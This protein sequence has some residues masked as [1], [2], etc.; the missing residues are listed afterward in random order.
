MI[1]LLINKEKAREIIVSR[2]QKRTFFFK[3]DGLWVGI[4]NRKGDAWI[5]KYTTL[6]ACTKWLRREEL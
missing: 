3:E 4:D 2:K 1:P 6:I 5:R